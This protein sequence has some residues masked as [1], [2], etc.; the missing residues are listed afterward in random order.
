MLLLVYKTQNI[1]QIQTWSLTRPDPQYDNVQHI[2]CCDTYATYAYD[3]DFE[4][5]NGFSRNSNASPVLQFAFQYTIIVL[6]EENFTKGSISLD[7]PKYSLKRRLKIRT[8]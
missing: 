1:S 7:R 8:L 3:F 2:I 4:N 6:P 5:N